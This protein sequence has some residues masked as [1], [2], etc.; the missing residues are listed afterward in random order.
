MDESMSQSLLKSSLLNRLAINLDTAE[1]FGPVTDL[2]VNG[3]TH[4]VSGL[5]CRSGLLGRQNRRFLWSQVASIGRDGVII[6]AGAQVDTNQDPLQGCLPLA[7]LELWSDHGERVGYVTDYRFELTTGNILQYQFVAD[8]SSVLEPGLYAISPIAIIS[9][10]RRRMMAETEQLLTATQLDLE[11]L[12]PPSTTARP[13]SNPWPRDQWPDPKSS[14]NTARQTG[15]QTREQ[16]VEQLGEHRQRLQ[17]NAQGQLG[18]LFSDVKKR[19]RHL[20]YQLRETVTDVTA[21]LPSR[22]P[23][24]DDTMPTIDV[25]AM[26]SWAD[27]DNLKT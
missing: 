7:E 6:R 18:R 5:G 27:E 3:R 16:V 14:W 13:R 9:T 25:N 8:S 19:T 12:P 26:E 20:R 17:A 4:Q 23:L 24:Q 2:W 22:S 15:R 21:G 1:E 11:T 10:G